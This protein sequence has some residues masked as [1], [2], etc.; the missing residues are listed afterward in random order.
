M[1][2]ARSQGID[3]PYEIPE[4]PEIHVDTTTVSAEEAA[5]EIIRQLAEAGI[6]SA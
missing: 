6:V 1:N 2:A 4:S 3:S 5:D